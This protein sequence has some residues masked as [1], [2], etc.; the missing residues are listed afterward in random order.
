M[1]ASE[2]QTQEERL[3]F[4]RK[5]HG[6]SPLILESLTKTPQEA[7]L[8]IRFFKRM[9]FLAGM[10]FLTIAISIAGLGLAKIIQQYILWGVIS[11]L[12][13]VLLSIYACLVFTRQVRAIR[14]MEQFIAQQNTL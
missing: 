7:R 12:C 4:L 13:G 1:A 8:A 6:I 10:T 2:N 5:E 3:S 14:A 11:L 9:T